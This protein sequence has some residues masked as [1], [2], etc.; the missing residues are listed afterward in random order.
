MNIIYLAGQTSSGKSELAI[1]LAKE[2]ESKNLR[3]WIVS[4]DSRQVY[5][6]LNIGTGKVT[7][8]WKTIKEEELDYYPEK[9]IYFYK[10]IPH[11]LIDYIDSKN[12]FEYGLVDYL[13]DF[14]SLF[15]KTKH[16]PDAVILTG[17]T[18]F[19][20]R[21]I[22]NEYDLKILNPKHQD[23]FE[24]EKRKLEKLNKT[25][26]QEF[27]QTK[28][29]K[30]LNNSDFNNPRKLINFILQDIISENNWG[31]QV[32][33]PK[34]KN[35][36]RFAIRLEQDKLK[37]KIENRLRARVNSGLI[38]EIQENID[39]GYG[40]FMKLGLEYRLGWYYLF[41]F[42]NEDE[43]RAKLIQENLQY[44]KRQLTWLKKD[45][46][47]WIKS[48]NEILNYLTFL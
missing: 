30:P 10:N 45:P 33:Y 5:Q 44:A 17:G 48:L 34:F 40:K 19:Y 16:H 24:E 7:G 8:S 23:V 11:F 42:L 37:D 18:G 41:G 43:F 25:D 1:S 39:L 15:Q 14:N 20:A 2:L 22:L 3:I 29:L 38:Q 35:K 36:Y 47:I 6:N 12:N 27:Y 9:S 31:Q 26:L 28:D 13:K 21:T 46:I 4:C 32:E